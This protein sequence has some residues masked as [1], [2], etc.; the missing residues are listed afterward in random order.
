[1][2]HEGDAKT[3]TAL[4]PIFF[5]CK[6]LVA[7]SFRCC[8]LPPILQN[9]DDKAVAVRQ[10]VLISFVDQNLKSPT[11]KPSDLTALRLAIARIAVSNWYRD[12][13]SPTGMHRGHGLSSPT[14]GGPRVAYV[15][16]GSLRNRLT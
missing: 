8:G 5:L 2:Y 16:S 11:E 7:A 3:I 15:V 9:S 1:M 14:I 4:R 6:T 12:R 10:G 13:T